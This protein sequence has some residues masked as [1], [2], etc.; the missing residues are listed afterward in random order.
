VEP[1][2]AIVRTILVLFL[3]LFF[4]WKFDG[5]EKIPRTGPVIIAPNH[6][7]NFDPLSIAYLVDHSGRRPRFLAKAS[8]W[9]NPLM[10]VIFSGCRQIPVER[11]SCDASPTRAAEDALR[12]G[13]CIVVYP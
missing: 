8:L 13:E 3:R 7:S 10:R 9:K 5:L 6:I 2:Y 1:I 4:R 11:G 12:R